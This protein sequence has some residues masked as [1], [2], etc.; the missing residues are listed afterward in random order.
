M[1]GSPQEF[2]TFLAAQIAKWP[3]VL[4]AANVQP[5]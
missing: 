5:Q 2:K 4:K 1:T 3:P